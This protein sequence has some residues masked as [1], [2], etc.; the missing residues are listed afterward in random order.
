M[1]KGGRVLRLSKEYRDSKE[2]I[3]QEARL[4]FGKRKQIRD[5]PIGIRMIMDKSRADIDAYIKIILD[6]FQGVVYAN[7]KQIRKLSV[8]I[9]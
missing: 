5:L 1:A 7:D 8:E 6:A 3:R 4:K 9:I 2:A